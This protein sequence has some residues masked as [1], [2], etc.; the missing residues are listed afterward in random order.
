MA[1]DGAASVSGDV[2]RVTRLNADGTAAIG[3]SASYVTQAFISVK[4]T[5]QMEAGIDITQKAANGSIGISYKVP[6]TLK[7]INVDVAIFNPNPELAEMLQG[8]TILGA[9]KGYAAPK[10]GEV[11]NPQGVA[12]E[13]WAKAIVNGRQAAVDP[14]WRWLLPF[15][16]MRMTG[17]RV[18]QEGVL[19]TN[20]TGWGT[21]N[22]N[23]GTGP[24]SATPT[25]PWISD[26]AYAYAREA[27]LPPI[28]AEGYGY[29]AT[30]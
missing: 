7:R 15:N 30:T 6:D 14:Y 10:F 21:G 29:V 3:P 11:S 13:V 20:F 19:A 27:T 24:V 18:I 26:R 8:G 16:V 23:F 25:W 9:S 22:A 17:D 12:I 4:I 1:Y 2:I 5:P 28:P